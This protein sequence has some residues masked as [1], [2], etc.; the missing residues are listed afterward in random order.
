MSRWT[1]HQ[2]P[3]LGEEVLL[4]T[5]QGGLPVRVAPVDRFAGVAAVVSFEYGSVDL[6]FTDGGAPHQSPEGVAHY[7]EHKLFEDKELKAFDRFAARGAH[8]NAMTGFGRTTYYFTATSQ[9]E[10]NLADLLHLVSHAHITPANVDK[11]R[12]IIAQELAMYLDSPDYRAFFDLLGCLYAEHP[13]RHP[14]GGTRE[15]IQAI[16]TEE[17]LRC[18]RAF[19][20]TGNAA[21][22]VAGCVDP[23]RVLALAD[24]CP[25][26]PGD[27][28]QRLVA[29]DLGPPRQPRSERALQVARPRVMLGFKE[30][31][32]CASTAA[33]LERDLVSRILLDR[34]LGAASERRERLRQRGLI[35]DSLSASYLSDRSFGFVV[36][37]CETEQPE[38]TLAALH[39]A[40]QEPLLPSAAGLEPVRRKQLGAFVRSFDQVKGLAFAHAAEAIDR[41]EPFAAWHRLQ[42]VREEQVVARQQE[43]FAGEASAVAVVLGETGAP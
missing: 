22:A 24:A 14:V 17:L 34:L 33:R 12:G 10:A 30:R 4:A 8:V 28:P 26:P 3:V 16:D 32:L 11:E 15:S 7:L 20:R 21:L 5:S 23:E 1:R 31:S 36:L 2:D 25:L 40:V 6:G 27:A 9:A 41:Q 38:A 39:E 43:L 19:Y 35:D 37:S 13:I 18:W 42:A 29:D